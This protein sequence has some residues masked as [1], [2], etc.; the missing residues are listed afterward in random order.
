MTNF[1]WLSGYGNTSVEFLA[2][3]ISDHSPT[4]VSAE[5]YVSYGPKPFKF[6]NFWADHKDFLD[7][8]KKG[9]N[10]DQVGFSMF[11]L[12]TKF[13]V[14]KQI[15]IIKNKEIFCGLRQRVIKARQDLDV[16]QAA[17]INSHGSMRCRL[18]ENECLHHYVSIS[19]AEEKFLKQKSR[20]QWLNLRNSNTSFFFLHK[21]VKV[22]NSSN[23]IKSIK[24]EAGVVVDDN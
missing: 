1:S 15:L 16:A 20:V 9:W 6:F 12:Y 2:G 17:F 19:L 24:D 18:R 7:W 4:L 21:M 22:R 23:L 11:Q 3:G 5:K 14:V 8:I 13:K 10:I